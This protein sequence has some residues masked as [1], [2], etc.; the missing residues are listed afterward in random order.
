MAI[1]PT[2][3]LAV[4]LL[5]APISAAPR[6]AQRPPSA[7]SDSE[8]RSIE[9]NRYFF[10]RKRDPVF[11]GILSWY[12]PGLGQFYSGEVVKGTAFLVTEY[13]LAICAIFYFLNFDFNAGGGSGFHINIDAKRSD[14]GVVETSRRN[15]FMGVMSLVA[16]IHLYNISDAVSSARA[17]NEELDRRR[18]RLRNEYPFLFTSSDSTGSTY[19]GI[20]QAF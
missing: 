3:T 11:A 18:I 6:P 4:F 17:F 20:Q 7:P 10:E 2:C 19:I 5:A 9:Y 13:T 14:L 12:V 8:L 16:V 1:A 15:V